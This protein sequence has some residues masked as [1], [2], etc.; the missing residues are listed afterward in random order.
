MINVLGLLHHTDASEFRPPATAFDPDFIRRHAKT[1][2]QYGYDRVLIG[3]HARAP[4]SLSIAA[5]AAACTQKLK[6]MIAHRPGFV[7]PTMAARMFATLDRMSGGRCAAHIITAANDIETQADGDFLTKDERYARSREYVEI[8]RAIW[9]SDA[10]LDHEGRFYRFSA[11]SC[12][13]KPAGGSIPVFW[14]GASPLGIEYGARCADVYAMGGQ[15]LERAGALVDAVRAVARPLGR[16]P[17]F[18]MS[19]RVILGAT[20]AAAWRK[21]RAILQA[22]TDFQNAGGVIGREKGEADRAAMQEAEI[23]AKGPD[24]YLWTGLTTATKGRTH[25]TALVGAPDQ[26]ISALLRYAALGVNNFILTGFDPIPDTIEIGRELIT[27]L[28]TPA[29]ARALLGASQQG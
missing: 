6:F 22:I 26:L 11:G 3:Q 10:P 1:L 19:F 23:A 25:I 5:Y 17:A 2:D 18:C 13:A 21:A 4:D 28:K 15:S 9:S 24:P 20:E 29:S 27:R 8:L 14:G 12:D 7:A 16:H